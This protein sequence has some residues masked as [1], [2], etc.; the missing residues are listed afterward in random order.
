MAEFLGT[1][2]A[3][4]AFGVLFVS[5][6]RHLFD[7]Y[8]LAAALAFRSNAARRDRHLLARLVAVIELTTGAFGLALTAGGASDHPLFPICLGMTTLIYAA[9]TVWT[10]RLVLAR[11]TKPCGCTNENHP[12]NLWTVVRAGALGLGGVAGLAVG[13]SV[14]GLGLS[15]HAVIAGN[16]S[17]AFA[18]L[19]WNL[20]SALTTDAMRGP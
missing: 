9:Y 1:V 8:P 3:L 18:S 7:P 6:G 12:A 5:G 19:L 14:L 17:I 11:S 10:A 13:D 20:P 15:V 4:T 2:G 16:A